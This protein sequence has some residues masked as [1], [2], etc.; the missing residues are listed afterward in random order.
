MTLFPY[1]V[2]KKIGHLREFAQIRKMGCTRILAN[3]IK[4]N[5]IYLRHGYSLRMACCASD[6]V[7]CKK[8]FLYVQLLIFS[9]NKYVTNKFDHPKSFSA[10]LWI[11]KSATKALELHNVTSTLLEFANQ[12]GAR[13]RFL[14]LSTSACLS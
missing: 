10:F 3:C 9:V 14:L 4:L 2:S 5:G 8:A 1:G 6:G 7:H 12:V 13:T 11:P